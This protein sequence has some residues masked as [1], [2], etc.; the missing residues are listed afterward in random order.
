MKV[1]GSIGSHIGSL[2]RQPFLINELTWSPTKIANLMFLECVRYFTLCWRGKLKNIEVPL[3][4][5]EWETDKGL[6]S[7]G[8]RDGGSAVRISPS[9]WCGY[10]YH[11]T[12]EYNLINYIYSLV[13]LSTELVW[14]SARNMQLPDVNFKI[15]VSIQ[16]LK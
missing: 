7:W 10:L 14:M 5:R 3:L 4:V 12:P 9:F 16:K 13:Q 1:A 15:F 2:L 8:S 11:G 6:C